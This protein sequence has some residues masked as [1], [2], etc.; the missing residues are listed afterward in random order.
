MMSDWSTLF[1]DFLTVLAFIGLY[2]VVLLVA[3]W[4][5]DLLTPYKLMVEL[6]KKDNFAIGISLGGYFLATAI[7][8]VGVLA[9]PS[10]G[11]VE[12][13][14]AVGGYS[15]LG[16][17]F[18]NTSRW[19]LDKLAFNKFC[20]ITAI[21]EDQ[22][23]G[24]AAVRFGVYVGTGLIAA[25]S[26]NGQGG[27]VHT[28]VAFFVLG[29]ISLVAFTRLYDLITPYDLQKEIQDGNVSAGIAFGGTIV[30]VS[31]ILMNAVSGDFVGW[32]HNLVRFVQLAIPAFI[33]LPIVRYL[34]DKLVISGADLNREI[35]EDRNMAAGFL[36]STVMVCFAT[37][38]VT[39][40]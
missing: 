4:F 35:A 14:I 29:Q 28:A 12:D 13:L 23:C 17:V 24:M 2:G 37:V 6:V 25:G 31:I 38:L 3:K 22:N 1:A 19:C 27:G 9:G 5:K 26:L 39:L 8:F 36:E 33:V 11:L 16:I 20:N 7:I 21:V 32:T 40:I 34:M 30:A 15:M 18:L 10:A